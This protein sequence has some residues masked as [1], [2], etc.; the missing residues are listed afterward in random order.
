MDVLLPRGEPLVDTL[1]GPDV[2]LLTVPAPGVTEAPSLSECGFGEM[3]SLKPAAAT[4]ETSLP[5]SLLS[6]SEWDDNRTASPA[7]C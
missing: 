5:G 1:D 3:S 2:G 7:S 6:G 4:A